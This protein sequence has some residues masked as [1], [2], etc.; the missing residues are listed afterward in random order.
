M[1]SGVRAEVKVKN[2]HDCPIAKVCESHDT[3]CTKVTRTTT[4][5]G[6]GEVIEEFMLP[7]DI[8]VDSSEV[9]KVFSYDS[10]GVYRF[11]RPAGVGCAC[12]SVEKHNS[13]VVDVYSDESYLHLTFHVKDVDELREIMFDLRENYDEVKIKRF[14]RGDKEASDGDGMILI[15]SSRLTDRQKEVLEKAHT[16]GYFEH[17]KESNAGEVADK[18]DITTSTFTEHLAAAQKKLMRAVVDG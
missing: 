8:E 17:P 12:E 7:G 5:E 4:P 1:S 18:L 14:L 16:L 13:P 2:P 11:T 10:N 6:D 9:E 3:T 15:D